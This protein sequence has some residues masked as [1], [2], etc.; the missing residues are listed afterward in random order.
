MLQH[1]ALEIK[2]ED[3]QSFYID[4]LGGIVENQ[5]PLK[6]EDAS[7]IFQINKEV[8]VYFLKINDLILELFVNESI[9]HKSFQHLCI[10]HDK[11]LQVFQKAKENKY[12][13]FLRKKENGFTCFIKDNN[14]NMFEIKKNNYGK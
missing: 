10:T 2:K 11:A 5:V 12:W 3:L 14:K 7:N 4:I 8:P 9:E 13:T 6:K 1:I